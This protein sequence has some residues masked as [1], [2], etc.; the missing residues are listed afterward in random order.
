MRTGDDKTMNALHVIRFLLDELIDRADDMF[1][2]DE[3]VTLVTFHA[4]V[5]AAI[6]SRYEY[7]PSVSVPDI[8]PPHPDT[9][10]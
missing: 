4:R 3:K 2:S 6:D 9:R 8:P 7:E 1:D 10:M 5:S